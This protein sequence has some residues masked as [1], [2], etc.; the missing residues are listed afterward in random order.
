MRSAVAAA[1]EE[2]N[3]E[4]QLKALAEKLRLQQAQA[5]ISL[6]NLRLWSGP[7]EELESLAVPAVETIQRFE[8]QFEE[9]DQGLRHLSNQIAAAKED[10]DALS[11]QI[12]ALRSTGEIPTEGDL[13]LA[14]QYRETGWHLVR[15]AWLDRKEEL[16]ELRAYSGD[17]PLPEAYEMSV[18]KADHLLLQRYESLQ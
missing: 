12:D 11:R 17:V 13:T 5:C 10:V 6:K 7:V 2:G 18:Q 8:R 15:R 1:V 14:R 16:Q 9:G 3:L 4:K